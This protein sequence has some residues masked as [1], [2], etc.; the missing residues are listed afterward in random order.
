MQ[1]VAELKT[2]AEE[3]AQTLTM[4]S[5]KPIKDARGEVSRTIDTFQVAA[6]ESIRIYG[7]HIPLDISARNKGLQVNTLTSCITFMQLL[8]LQSSKCFSSS[9]RI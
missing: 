6:E 8:I 9:G 1:V 7:E 5:G 4:E 2:R 3:I